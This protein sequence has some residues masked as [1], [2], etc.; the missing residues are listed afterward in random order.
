MVT[1]RKKDDS[2]ASMFG[3]KILSRSEVDQLE[4]IDCCIE[5]QN[6]K[7]K[8]RKKRNLPSDIYPSDKYSV[9]TF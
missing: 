6:G 8:R 7:K 2:V 1:E 4:V 5:N 3:E 9:N